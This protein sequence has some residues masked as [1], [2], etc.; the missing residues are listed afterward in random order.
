MSSYSA[1]HP[2]STIVQGDRRKI[3]VYDLTDL[4]DVNKYIPTETFP[5]QWTLISHSVGLHL[6]LERKIECY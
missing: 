5:I 6:Q 1:G 4:T 2:V 3:A